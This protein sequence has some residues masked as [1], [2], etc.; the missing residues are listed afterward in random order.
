[1][2][3]HI[4]NQIRCHWTCACIQCVRWI[5]V[6]CN[7]G[8]QLT[9]IRVNPVVLLCWKSCTLTG[10]DQVEYIQT[11]E[12]EGK[13]QPNESL[14]QCWRRKY[15]DI[16]QNPIYPTNTGMLLCSCRGLK[17]AEAGVLRLQCLWYLDI[18]CCRPPP[19]TNVEVEHFKYHKRQELCSRTSSFGKGMD[20]IFCFFLILAVYQA[21][22]TPFNPPSYHHA[23]G[24]SQCW[25]KSGIL[26]ATVTR[27]PTHPIGVILHLL[28]WI[29][30]HDPFP[31]HCLTKKTW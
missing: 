14:P 21:N 28:S 8:K 11:N 18:C 5:P 2:P 10:T 3:G 19:L 9:W 27:W 15:N 25:Q 30:V 13:Y 6:D 12:K 1:M 26:G 29:T 16:Q 20:V 23:H 22:V 7:P 24:W 17:A 4:P 31:S